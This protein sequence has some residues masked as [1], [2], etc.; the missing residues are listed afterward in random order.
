M[1]ARFAD[2][3]VHDVGRFTVLRALLLL[4]AAGSAAVC[5]RLSAG[6]HVRRAAAARAVDCRR[7]HDGLLCTSGLADRHQQLQQQQPAVGDSGR[8]AGQ[9][10]HTVSGVYRERT[11]THTHTPV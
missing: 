8:H 9:S 5:G 1:L 6:R 3:A 4:G 7:R 10:S 11:H 2:T